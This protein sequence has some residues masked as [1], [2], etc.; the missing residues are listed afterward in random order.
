MDAK[1]KSRFIALYSM[2]LADGIIDAREME[3]LYRIGREN[4]G[5]PAEEINDAIRESGI[6]FLIPETL[7]EKISFLYHLAEIALSDEDLDETEKTLLR[8]YALRMGFLEE[9]ANEI[10]D[11]LLEQVRHKK[12]LEQVLNEINN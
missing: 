1:T 2:I 4:Y 3:T 11:W 10:V 5:I 7:N 9:N 6:S 8:K 12:T